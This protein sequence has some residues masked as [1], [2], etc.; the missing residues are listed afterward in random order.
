M[1]DTT[2]FNTNSLTTNSN[3]TNPENVNAKKNDPL[4]ILFMDRSQLAMKIIGVMANIV[5]FVTLTTNG[6]EF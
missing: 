2:L 6:H 4:W 3:G 5:T 1:E